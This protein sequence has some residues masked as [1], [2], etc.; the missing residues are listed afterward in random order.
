MLEREEIAHRLTSIVGAQESPFATSV[1]GQW[2]TGKTFLLTRWRQ[3]LENRGWRAI[4]F[5]A[6]DDDFHDDP[7][8]RDHRTALGLPRRRTTP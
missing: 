3:D 6:W 8:A 4:Y 1:D 5:N 7:A 2:G